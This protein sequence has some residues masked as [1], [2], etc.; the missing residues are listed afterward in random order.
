MFYLY[1]MNI[2]AVFI[3]YEKTPMTSAQDV[4]FC[5]V[6][7]VTAPYLVLKI[8]RLK[9]DSSTDKSEN[10]NKRRGPVHEEINPEPLPPPALHYLEIL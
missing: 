7:D 9:Q 8:V 6:A 4:E 10:R 3:C 2:A 1:R 5:A